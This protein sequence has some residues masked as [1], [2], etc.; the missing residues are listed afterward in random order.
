[1]I[2]EQEVTV[3]RSLAAQVAEEAAHPRQQE[4]ICLWQRHNDLLDDTPLVFIDPENGWHEIIP[5]SVMQCAD[6]Q[7]R[8]WEF[9]LRRRLHWARVLRDDKPITNNLD[10]SWVYSS[11]GFGL[12]PHRH[13]DTEHG[14]SCKAEPVIENYDAAFQKLHL[15]EIVIDRSASARLL[16]QAQETFGD[17]LRVRQRTFWWWSLGMCWDFIDLRGFENFLCD[18]I[19]EPENFHRMMRFLCD[20]NL[21]MLDTLEREKLLSSNTDVYVG[22]GGFGYTTALPDT[23]VT[24]RDMW[25]FVEAQETVSISPAMYGEFIFP[26][27]KELASRFGLNYYGCCEP[28]ETR[29]QYVRQLPN[30]RRVSVC[31]W[32]D[33]S[34]V[35]QLLGHDYVACIKLKPTPLARQTMDEDEVRS[36]CRRAVEQSRGGIC[37]FI[38]KDNHTLGGNPDNARRWVEIMREEI[39]R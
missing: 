11:T 31:P 24:T 28:Y 16:E 33:V 18:M 15:P 34:T 22:S 36:D 3:L 14:G 27:H 35:P 25:G 26:Y 2:S 29:W 7:A 8:A 10:V 37:E 5:D 9:D 20:S 21:H 19:D 30:L 23:A 1:M 17:L 39:A 32:S 13:G 4:K 6:P 12:T 38:M